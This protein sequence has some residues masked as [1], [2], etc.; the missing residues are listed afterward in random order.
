M[1][2][3]ILTCLIV[4]LI[5]IALVLLVAVFAPCKIAGD[6]LLVQGREKRVD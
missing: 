2:A 6:F 1:I 4:F 3:G 5:A